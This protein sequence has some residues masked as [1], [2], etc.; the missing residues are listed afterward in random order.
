MVGTG[1]ET[2]EEK[3][4]GNCEKSEHDT[5]S[6]T[7]PQNI[8]NENEGN[9]QSSMEKKGWF[10]KFEILLFVNSESFSKLCQTSDME[11]FAVIATGTYP[12][13]I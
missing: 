13:S 2:K 10:S 4:P 1:I 11:R 8:S 7:I 9:I 3:T 5:F 12:G 6:S